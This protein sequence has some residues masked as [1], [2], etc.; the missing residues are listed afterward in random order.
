M[1]T[2]EFVSKTIRL[3]QCAS[4]MRPISLAEAKPSEPLSESSESLSEPSEPSESLSVCVKEDFLLL[5]EAVLRAPVSAEE[6]DMLLP[7]AVLRAPASKTSAE[8]LSVCVVE[9]DVLLPEPD[10]SV[11]V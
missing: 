11:S 7:E 5:S 9:D 2:L 6:D 4:R 1:H 3:E 8:S 10:A